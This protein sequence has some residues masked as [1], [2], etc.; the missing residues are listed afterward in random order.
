M[1]H[2]FLYDDHFQE[3]GRVRLDSKKRVAIPKSVRD[4]ATDS[5]RVFVN[6]A[7]QIMLDPQ[8]T[9]PATEAWL[10]KNPKALGRLRKGLEDLKNKKLIKRGSFTKYAR[11]P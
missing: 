11:D 1:E 4:S 6:Q 7:G 5:Y 10:I 8:V 3:I 9:I 2:T